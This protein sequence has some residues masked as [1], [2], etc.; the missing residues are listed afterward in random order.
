LEHLSGGTGVKS[1]LSGISEVGTTLDAV[2]TNRVNSILH[3]AG[4]TRSRV[5]EKKEFFYKS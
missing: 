3:K 4:Q 5:N 2:K 1:L